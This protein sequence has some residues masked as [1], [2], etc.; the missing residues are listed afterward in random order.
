MSNNEQTKSELGL[1]AM[2]SDP[3]NEQLDSAFK[4]LQ[5]E[6][7]LELADSAE[8]ITENHNPDPGEIALEEVDEIE[9]KL[10]EEEGPP[11]HPSQDDGMDLQLSEDEQ[12][13][14]ENMKTLTES[15]FEDVSESSIGKNEDYDTDFDESEDSEDE[16]VV[17]L[18]DDDGLDQS[19]E[20]SK[21]RENMGELSFP[22][23]DELSLDGG[24][25]NFEGEISENEASEEID[26]AYDEVLQ[27][28]L[29]IGLG[30][31]EEFASESNLNDLSDDALKKLQE[32]DE[33]MV[34][35]LSSI[36]IK[37][38]LLQ[39]SDID[40]SLVSEDLNLDKIEFSSDEVEEVIEEKPKRKKK[41]ISD[42]KSDSEY[43]TSADLKEISSAYSGDIERLQATLSNLRSDREELLLKIQKMEEDKV[44][45]SRQSLSLRA[46]LDE[47]KIELTIIRKKLN[48]EILELKDSIK[49][50]E[51][52]KLILEE[53]NRF[54]SV[55]LDKSNQKNK[56]DVKRIQLREKEL[57]QKL[58]LLKSDAETQIRNRD[59][60]ILELKRR[61]DGMEFDMESISQQEKKSVES[62]FE[63]EDKLEKT[64]KTL[65]SAISSL[66][67]ENDKVDAMKAL[68]RNVDM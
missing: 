9:I 21:V 18:E 47:K 49:I 29:L 67:E 24:I 41:E 25:S 50:H 1:D 40:Q 65:R 12:L 19:L 57:E 8:S 48:E 61:I 37:S 62:R 53:K 11:D 52:K 44:L 32:I 15:E 59:L 28:E 66:E 35:D 33:I 6:D 54:L 22:E 38:E 56:I 36:G 30:P 45:Q 31:E 60:K 68:K 2:S 43:Q 27:D 42:S 3:V 13:S 17:N 4:E 5:Q 55:E 10:S 46:E 26:Q 7:S 14:V 16:F 23:N 64:I 58:E 20:D 51:E 63:L 34:S 39:V